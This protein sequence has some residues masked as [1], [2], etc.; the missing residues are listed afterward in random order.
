MPEQ[1]TFQHR[2][3]LAYLRQSGRDLREHLKRG[4]QF[5]GDFCGDCCGRRKR[6]GV[7]QALILDPE[8]VEAQSIAFQNLVVGEA[9]PSTI[10]IFLAPRCLALGS[11]FRFVA[12]GELVEA[13]VVGRRC[14][15]CFRTS[16]CPGLICGYPFGAKSPRST[17]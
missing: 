16:R 7:G 1:S 6:F 9:S 11:G 15:H 17:R 4:F 10:G 12:K 3:L 5:I 14:V 2:F 13:Y 8:Q